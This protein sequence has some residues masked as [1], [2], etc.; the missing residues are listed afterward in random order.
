MRNTIEKNKEFNIISRSIDNASKC[1]VTSVQ[2]DSFSVKVPK[3]SRF[4]TGESVELFAMTSKGQLYF[5]TLIKEIN[6]DILTIWFPISYKYLQ[7]REYSRIKTEQNTELTFNDNKINAV[8][9]DISAGGL[10][11]KTDVQL[12]L[13]NE[14]SIT[15]N[16]DNKLI[17]TVFEP[18]RTEAS[19]DGFISSGRFKNLNNYDRINLVQYCFIKQ[20]ERSNK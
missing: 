19:Q 7:R 6:N 12:K 14:Y 15:V 16:I 2:E 13:L 9:L 1:T 11:L 18:I 3:S 10:K 17:D 4:E 5:E 8:I 20:I